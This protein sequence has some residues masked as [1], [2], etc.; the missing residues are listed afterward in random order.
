MTGRHRLPNRRRD[1]SRAC[2]SAIV[3][4]IAIQHGAVPQAVRRALC[5]DSQGRA[6]GPLGAALDIIMGSDA[7]MSDTNTE[8]A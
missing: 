3:L 2:D 6:S 5:R 7:P 1:E 8:R 4:S